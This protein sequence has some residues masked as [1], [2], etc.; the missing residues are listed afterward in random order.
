MRKAQLARK[1]QQAALHPHLGKQ[2]MEEMQAGNMLVVLVAPALVAALEVMAAATAGTE[3]MVLMAQVALDREPPR[4]NLQKQQR[5]YI[6]AEARG[7]EAA[8]AL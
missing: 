6:L 1:V 2:P 4:E 7:K 5:R 8:I 3:V